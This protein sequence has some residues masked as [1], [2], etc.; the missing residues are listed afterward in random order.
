MEETIW[1]RKT[2]NGAWWR[3]V[4]WQGWAIT[5][6]WLA[7]NLWYIVRVG[8][9]SLSLTNTIVD[10]VPFFIISTIIYLL[11]VRTHCERQWE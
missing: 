10:T 11:I 2:F 5:G 4:S 1:F 7:L 6:S 3:P 9:L 8:K